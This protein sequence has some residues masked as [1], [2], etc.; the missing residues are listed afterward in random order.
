MATLLL[1]VNDPEGMIVQST[2]LLCGVL[3]T[4]TQQKWLPHATTTHNGGHHIMQSV[5][6]LASPQIV[7]ALGES[8]PAMLS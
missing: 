1:G 6:S 2:V 8:S 3:P 7:R 4:L 5:F